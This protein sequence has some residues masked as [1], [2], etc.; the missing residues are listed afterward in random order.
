M[1]S[2]LKPV[3]NE[4]MQCNEC[5][6]RKMALFK[7]VPED[8]L[9]WTQD[10]RSSQLVL[11]AKSFLYQE[12]EH[13][14]YV[15]TLYDGCIKLYKTLQ[16]GKIQAMRF[17][18]P[19]DFLGFQGDLSGPMHHGAQSLTECVVCAFPRENVSRML[20]EHPEI[21]SEL[22]VKNARVMAFCQEH[23]LSTGARSAYDSIAFTLAELDH[24]LKLLHKFCPD[25]PAFKDGDIPITQEDLAD[26]VGITPIHANRTLK[27]MREEGYITCG[28][29]KITVVNT[30]ALR[31]VSGFEPHV[32]DDAQ[33]F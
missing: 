20:C 21:A 4:E 33:M 16:N 28:K 24:R 2:Q 22:I 18:T 15:Y 1:N 26:A 7:K 11:P 5:P 17:A 30:K 6:I 8:K 12:G 29:G 9:S 14:D 13:H 3:T 27:Q 10:Y 32:L 25:S 31:E 23:L 19:G